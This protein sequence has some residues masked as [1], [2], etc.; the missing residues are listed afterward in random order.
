MAEALFHA[1]VDELTPEGCENI[2]QRL[3]L[4]VVAFRACVSDPSTDARIEADRAEF[5]AAGGFALPTLWIGNQPLVGAQPVETLT[6]AL[7]QAIARVG[8]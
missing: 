4:P 1:P 5:K 7:S 6:Q 3:R 2:A 8:G